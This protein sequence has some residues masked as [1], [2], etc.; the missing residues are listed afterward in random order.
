MRF[1]H[2]VFYAAWV[3]CAPKRA[4][5]SVGEVLPCSPELP[6]NQPAT[7]LPCQQL[8]HRRFFAGA[9]I[10]AGLPGRHIGPSSRGAR[11]E[12]RAVEQ[13]VCCC[14]TEVC[15]SS[16]SRVDG[17]AWPACVAQRSQHARR[18][19][20]ARVLWHA[21]QHVSAN[22]FSSLCTACAL[23]QPPWLS[24]QVGPLQREHVL[25]LLSAPAFTRQLAG[26]KLL[27]DLVRAAL[28]ALCCARCAC[29]AGVGGCRFGRR[30]TLPAHTGFGHI[31]WHCPLC[32]VAG[33]IPAQCLFP[34]GPTG[35][36]Y[37]PL[38][39]TAARVHRG[40]LKKWLAG[41]GVWRQVWSGG[42]AGTRHSFLCH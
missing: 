22:P 7:E 12:G 28:C 27:N 3:W 11:G 38:Q 41:Q 8:V 1:C 20:H 42:G 37:I 4:C 24:L 34:F 19:K 31:A 39:P 29:W 2:A 16:L 35:E 32:N 26:L 13:G 18:F 14:R 17:P 15:M 36:R 23:S 33:C 40:G 5:G 6:R 9:R 10:Y 25:R 21:H 30:A